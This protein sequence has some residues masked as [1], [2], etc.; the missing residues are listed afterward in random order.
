MIQ[1]FLER[2]RTKTWMPGTRQAKP[3]R[4]DQKY[5]AVKNYVYPSNFTAV[6]FAPHSSTATR[7]PA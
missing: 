1:V 7:S 4:D 5:P 3:G 6:V 2:W